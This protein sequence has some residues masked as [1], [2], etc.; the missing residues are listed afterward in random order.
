M[1]CETKYW[2]LVNSVF[3]L[4]RGA[5]VFKSGCDARKYTKQVFT[6]VKKYTLNNYFHCDKFIHPTIIFKLSN[7]F[8]TF[9]LPQTGIFTL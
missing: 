6:C 5:L 9:I 4:S 3:L 8:N 7:H 2:H 1:I